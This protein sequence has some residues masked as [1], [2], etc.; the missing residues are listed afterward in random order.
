MLSFRNAKTVDLYVNRRVSENQLLYVNRND[1]VII[2]ITGGLSHNSMLQTSPIS[3]D[4]IA[5]VAQV[6]NS[7][8]SQ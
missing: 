2:T 7:T 8:G 4:Q 1:I 3:A 5:L 6:P